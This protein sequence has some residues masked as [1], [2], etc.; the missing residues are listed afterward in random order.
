MQIEFLNTE[1]KNTELK[2]SYQASKNES[3]KILMSITGVDYLYAM[4]IASEI[5]D[6][7][8][9]STP[10]TSMVGWIMSIDSSIR[11]FPIHGKNE[12][13][14]QKDKVDTNSGSKYSSKERR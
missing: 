4:M 9:F 5:G 2:I 7:T 8:R 13:W 3:V 10:E 12:R 1:I 11:E 6:I 14:E